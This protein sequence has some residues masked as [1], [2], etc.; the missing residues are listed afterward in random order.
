MLISPAFPDPY[1][2]EKATPIKTNTGAVL[3]RF[4]LEAPPDI[5]IHRVTALHGDASDADAD[6]VR[7][8]GANA[9]PPHDWKIISAEG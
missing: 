5:L 4:W 8:Q 1:D 3:H 6:E 7:A 2:R 9:V